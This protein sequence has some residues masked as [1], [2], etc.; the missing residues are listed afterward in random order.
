V[1]NTDDQLPFETSDYE[2]SRR[3]KKKAKKDK[4]NR[5]NTNSHAKALANIARDHPSLPTPRDRDEQRG[6]WVVGVSAGEIEALDA[7]LGAGRNA[8]AKGT[9]RVSGKHEGK[10]TK[11][12]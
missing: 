12:R 6:A 11:R 2:T 9:G 7:D 8:G 10:V 3:R 1:D 4:R 5:R